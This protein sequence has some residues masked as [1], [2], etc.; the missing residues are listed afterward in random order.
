[1]RLGVFNVLGRR[2][3]ILVDQVMGPGNHSVRYAAE[4]AP[5]GFCL[6]RLTTGETTLQRKML[7][8]K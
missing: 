6:Y 3:A 4:D 7:L 1:M 8:L 2:E 5:T